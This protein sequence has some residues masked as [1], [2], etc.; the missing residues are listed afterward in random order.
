MHVAF[1][2]VSIAFYDQVLLILCDS[3][4]IAKNLDTISHSSVYTPENSDYPKIFFLSNKQL[5]NRE[6]ITEKGTAAVIFQVTHDLSTQKYPAHKLPNRR[7]GR[8]RAGNGGCSWASDKGM[9]GFQR[10]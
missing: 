1:R 2:H 3:H 6:L 8:L 10:P 5:L 9:F 4:L 7:N